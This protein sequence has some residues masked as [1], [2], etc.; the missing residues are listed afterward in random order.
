MKKIVWCLLVAHFCTFSIGVP[1]TFAFVPLAMVPAGSMGTALAPGTAG[2]VNGA[3]FYQKDQPL[4]VRAISDTVS[5]I[6]Q[7]SN[8]AI[9]PLSLVTVASMPSLQSLYLSKNS[10]VGLS[11]TDI[12]DWYNSLG[13][14]GV[15][16]CPQIA[17]A[18]A[19]A[20]VSTYDPA[21]WV[22]GDIIPGTTAD[23]K[24]RITYKEGYIATV[25]S[26]TGRNWL[27]GMTNQAWDFGGIVYVI[28]AKTG[29]SEWKCDVYGTT[30]DTSQTVPEPPPYINSSDPVALNNALKQLATSN[31]SE[32]KTAIKDANDARKKLVGEVAPTT[33]PT[34]ADVPTITSAE[35]AAAIAA[36]T[37]AVSQAAADTAAA[38]AAANP[39]DAALQIAAGQAAVNAARDAAN[40]ATGEQA[41]AEPAE[42]AQEPTYT[43]IS[44]SPFVTPYNPGSFSITDRFT[45]FLNTVKSSGLFSFSSSFFNSLPGGGSPV[46][47]IDA[48]QYGHHTID[49]SQTLS[50]GLAVLKTVLL[51]CFGFL[52]I[53]AVIMKR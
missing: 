7:P 51:A 25:N 32:L 34:A 41:V 20:Q 43:G 14:A 21:A 17:A 10:N 8:L 6:F 50:T 22:V 28:R 23:S 30:A 38:L 46:Y 47:E 44:D 27:Y 52:S 2:S 19:A 49:L 15:S 37:A 5:Y 13:A 12:V 4:T 31:S 42:D 36:N 45:S 39:T 18:V 40:A 53:R 16:I 26:L 11:T 29:T 1:R 35:I 24:K 48:G 9:G 33:A 3:K